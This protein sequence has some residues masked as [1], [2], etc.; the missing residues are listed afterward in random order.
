MR[1]ETM[2][3]YQTNCALLT[4][5]VDRSLPWRVANEPHTYR[6]LS[7]PTTIASHLSRDWLLAALLEH[8]VLKELK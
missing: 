8:I 4:Q 7:E 1:V 2:T 3:R 5:V 6:S